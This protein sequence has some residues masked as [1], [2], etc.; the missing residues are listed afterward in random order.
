MPPAAAAL[1]WEE[2]GVTHRFTLWLW[3]DYISH[4]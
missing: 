2:E 4:V 3:G 1:P